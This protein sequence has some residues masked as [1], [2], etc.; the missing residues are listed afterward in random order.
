MNSF[1]FSKL[2]KDNEVIEGT[3]G[4]YIFSVYNPENQNEILTSVM[5]EM[6]NTFGKGSKKNI[7]HIAKLREDANKKH[8]KYA[9]LVTELEPEFS[10]PIWRINY[11][12]KGNSVKDTYVVRPQYFILFLS[13]IEAIHHKF[14]DELKLGQELKEQYATVEEIKDVIDGIRN[15]ILTSQAFKKLDKNV[16]EIL[17]NNEKIEKNATAILELASKNQ[18]MADELINTTIEKFKTKINSFKI[19]KQKI[20]EL[21][22]SLNKANDF[23]LDDEE[24]E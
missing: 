9:L 4:D 17:D 22:E 7:D 8:C 6:K 11:D 3:K 5:C 23:L 19:T 1:A 14:I 21:S 10:L 20:K 18:L 16:R 13:L 2:E 15:K 12:N 24:S